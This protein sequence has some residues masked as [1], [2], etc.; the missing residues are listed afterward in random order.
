M[1]SVAE[2]CF[3]IDA[4]NEANKRFHW[5]LGNRLKVHH[6]HEDDELPSDDNRQKPNPKDVSALPTHLG[7]K[8]RAMFA[9]VETQPVPDRL[10]ELLEALAAKEKKPE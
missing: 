9:D 5:L 1:H 10:V 3:R 8:L 4:T 2:R 6:M 7:Q